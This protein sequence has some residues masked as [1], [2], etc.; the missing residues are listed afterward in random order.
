LK[1]EN[2]I[3]LLALKMNHTFP[4]LNLQTTKEF[5]FLRKGEQIVFMLLR[6]LFFGI[7]CSCVCEFFYF[8]IKSEGADNATFIC[9]TINSNHQH[10]RNQQTSGV[11]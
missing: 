3:F 2:P 5:G 10:I 9:C 8:L 4:V 6:A 1:I 11:V 7:I